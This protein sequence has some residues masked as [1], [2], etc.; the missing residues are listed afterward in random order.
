[1]ISIEQIESA[2]IVEVR[3]V[4]QFTLYEKRGI[5]VNEVEAAQAGG[6]VS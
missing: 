4:R 2:A 1:L 3:G 5:E 6:K